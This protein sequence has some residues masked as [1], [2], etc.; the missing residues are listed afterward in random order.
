MSSVREKKEYLN[1]YRELK[2]EYLREKEESEFWHSLAY[3]VSASKMDE[4]GV[5]KTSIS[6]FQP[7]DVYLDLE[8]KCKEHARELY[9]QKTEIR[10]AI[11]RIDNS[12][13]RDVLKKHYIYNY[14]FR[15]I[16]KQMFLGEG[17]VYKLH[18]KAINAFEIPKN[19]QI[20]PKISK[21]KMLK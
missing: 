14:S 8:E 7:V 12:I 17:Y 1:S 15:Y 13:Y 16:E 6:N 21:Q 5:T 20:Y 4:S 3:S 11:N 19:V 18:A 10:E 9:K 2:E